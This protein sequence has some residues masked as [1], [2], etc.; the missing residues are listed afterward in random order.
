M[1]LNEIP[2]DDDWDFDNDQM[3]HQ[4]VANPKEPD[5]K[6]VKEPVFKVANGPFSVSR[7][8]NYHIKTDRIVFAQTE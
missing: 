8:L 1:D 3:E 4:E 2:K 6:V 5:Y 7:Q